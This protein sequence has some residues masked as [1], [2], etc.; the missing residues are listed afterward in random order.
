MSRSRADDLLIQPAIKLKLE[1]D[2]N[3]M[4]LVHL[5]G[6]LRISNQIAG[7]ITDNEIRTPDNAD[8]CAVENC[9]TDKLT[10]IKSIS[11]VVPE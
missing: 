1:A 6:Q 2:F 5:S 9:I 4:F 3:V 7:V 10:L 8:L 11:C